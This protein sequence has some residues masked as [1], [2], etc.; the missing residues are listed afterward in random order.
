MNEM[1]RLATELTNTPDLIMKPEQLDAMFRLAGLRKKPLHDAL[2]MLG[3]NPYA[4]KVWAV[5]DRA[6]VASAVV[7]SMLY[8]YAPGVP[9]GTQIGWLAPQYGGPHWFIAYPLEDV[10]RFD[11]NIHI[12]H[13]YEGDRYVIIDLL[14]DVA[15][16]DFRYELGRIMPRTS[17][18]W[19]PMMVQFLAK[20][21][22]YDFRNPYRSSEGWTPSP[23]VTAECGFGDKDSANASHTALGRP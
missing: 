10:R 13:T 16:E 1:D 20:L 12:E 23:E 4:P 9:D 18:Y 17:E 15:E 22:G 5:E 11:R 7:T 21:Y 2:R 14:G 3:L 19:P 6:H 8:C